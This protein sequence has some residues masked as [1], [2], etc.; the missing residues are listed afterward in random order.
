[1]PKEDVL[2]HEFKLNETQTVIALN[3]LKSLPELLPH[4]AVKVSQ[5]EGK[6]LLCQNDL[7]LMLEAE[8]SGDWSSYSFTINRNMLQRIF[9]LG[10]II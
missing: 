7:E 1:M 9:Q 4:N 6:L 10:D 3:F 2:T 8:F 5:N